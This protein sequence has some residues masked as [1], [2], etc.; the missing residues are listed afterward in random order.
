MLNELSIQNIHQLKKTADT[1]HLHSLLLCFSGYALRNTS[2]IKK[3]HD[4]LIF[5]CAF[6]PNDKINKLVKAELKRI[7]DAAKLFYTKNQLKK[8]TNLM[9]SGIANTELF[10]SYSRPI[11]SWL[12]IKFPANV[13]L[14]YSNAS[15]DAVRNIFQLLLPAVEYEKS[16][17][18]ELNLRSRIKFITGLHNPGEQLKWLV[19]IFDNS[20]LPESVKDELYLQLKIY[21]LWK[22]DDLN[23]NR[24]FL[25]W[26]VKNTWHQKKF[27]KK[28][29][30]EKILKQKTGSP[31][32]LST[33]ARMKVLDI[34]KASLAFQYRETDPVTYAD[35]KEIQLFEMGRG[36][37]I[38]IVGMKKEKRLSL[39]SYIGFMAFKNGVPLS[40][41]GGWIWGQ[42]CKI[43][44]NIYP[45]FR[46]GES[47][48]LFC[49]VLRLYYYYFGI[50]YFVVKPYQFGKGNPEGLTSGAFWFYYKIGFRP[51]DEKIKEVAN[52]E[53][54]KIQLNKN[55][56]TSLNVL[57]HFTSCNIE[58][59]FQKKIDPDFDAA[60]IS[61][62]ITLLINSAYNRNRSTAISVLL[63]KMKN[64]LPMGLLK[65]NSLSNQHVLEN[66]C[67]LTGL[68]PD[69]PKWNLQ[70]KRKF[71]QLIHL[72]QNGKER[73]YIIGL[74]K[75][76][77]L[78]KSLR[79]IIKN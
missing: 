77:R 69:L 67:L 3:Y 4:L 42:R 33:L 57:R 16:T 18:R 35:E 51:V 55:Y 32:P 54:K 7:A 22:L 29:N 30:S 20:P 10:C 72:K 71:V 26:P 43:G 62:A 79:L 2:V 34:M 41:G 13:K 38:A 58:W 1:N 25:N 74:Q 73:D 27:I 75:H 24:I 59:K 39:E 17:Q 47:A 52:L 46:R 19:Q 48:W 70:Q 60:R 14:G 44:V 53:W 45:G 9:A 50:R 31:L 12:L 40:Y 63:K 6:P 28:I 64:D 8:Q 15:T 21:V 23:Y 78:W 76:N 65:H 5:Y 66:W 11:L 68:I 37:Q 56:R 49:Q 61:E 36:L